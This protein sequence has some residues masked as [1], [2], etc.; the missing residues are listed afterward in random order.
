MIWARTPADGPHAGTEPACLDAKDLFKEASNSARGSTYESVLL[1]RIQRSLE[2]A[3]HG[4]QV[5][6][7]AFRGSIT[8]GQRLSGGET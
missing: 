5:R 8:L 1:P 3:A 7:C 6:W 4:V 2:R